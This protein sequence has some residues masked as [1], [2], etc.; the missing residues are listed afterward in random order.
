M[1]PLFMNVQ[2]I[3]VDPT[4]IILANQ[5]LHSLDILCRSK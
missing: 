3:L 2:Y 1:Q 5:T 4:N